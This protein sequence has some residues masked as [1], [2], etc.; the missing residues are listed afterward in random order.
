MTDHPGAR[1]ID[2]TRY[3]VLHRFALALGIALTLQVT[4]AAAEELTIFVTNETFLPGSQPGLL[5]GVLDGD[6]KCQDRADV[7]NLPG[8]FKAWL[9]DDN[10]NAASRQASGGGPYVLVDD[11]V[12]ADDWNDLTDGTLDHAIDLDEFGNPTSGA[13]VW[14]GTTPP[15]AVIADKTCGWW[16][17]S[18]GTGRRGTSSGTDGTWSSAT[19]GD[20]SSVAHLYCIECPDPNHDGA[21]DVVTTTTT[22]TT[23]TSTTTSTTTTTTTTL[24]PMEVSNFSL[25][26]NFSKQAN[27]SMA[28]SG[29][30]PLTALSSLASSTASGDAGGVTFSAAL[31]DK[32]KAVSPDKKT[33]VAV[34]KPKAGRAKFS[35]KLNKG[36]FAALLADEGLTNVTVT[37][38][39][40]R[41][42]LMLD[43]GGRRYGATVDITYTGKAGKSGT[44]AAKR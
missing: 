31:N 34:S 39:P 36:N 2:A 12:V 20:C 17:S 23:T 41:I 10:S 22:T 7:A 38:A 28:F 40:R 33:S 11:T 29:S 30:I 44:A 3:Q 19:D 37:K 24:L 15:G 4:R 43:L 6:Q 13:S 14:T 42:S 21:C 9:S 26:L 27:D 8:T 5:S 1:W 16:F 18:V 32:G 35:T 25:K